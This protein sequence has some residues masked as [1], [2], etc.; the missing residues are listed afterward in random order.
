[1]SLPRHPQSAQWPF[2]APLGD[3]E[4]A[5]VLALAEV[6]SDDH[7]LDLGC[8]DGRVVEAAL[9][10]GAF[11]TGIEVHAELAQAAQRRLAPWGSRA[12][13]L[14]Q[15]FNTAELDADVVFAYLSPAILQRLSNRLSQLPA[16]IR[17]VTAWFP[18]P[19][20][21]PVRR[22]GNCHL[23]RLPPDPAPT[24][25][26]SV[27][28]WESPGVLCFLPPRGKYLVTAALDHPAG[29]VRVQASTSIEGLTE[30]RLGA[31]VLDSPA[32]IAVDVFF[33]PRP[34]GT[35]VSGTLSSPAAGECW[36]LGLYHPD[37]WGHWPLDATMF[38]RVLA[39]FSSG[40]RIP[41]DDGDA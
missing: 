37:S 19:G 1:V 2:W 39:Q 11:A 25:L 13:V 31:D 8:G 9:R 41:L 29:P 36:L 6:H 3:E 35:T 38:R 5:D 23:Y 16:G 28:S 32:R 22:H 26:D 33:D 24:P 21:K 15:D 20:W 12:R 40:T 10:A 18:V 34:P 7:F 17:V 27:G 14:H 30:L 4:I